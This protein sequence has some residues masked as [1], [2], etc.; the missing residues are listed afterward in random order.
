MACLGSFALSSWKVEGKVGAEEKDKCIH[1]PRKS[2]LVRLIGREGFSDAGLH[3]SPTAVRGIGR[4]YLAAYCVPLALLVLGLALSLLLGLQQWILPNYLQ[5]THTSP[6][7][8]GMI[9]LNDLTLGVITTMP[10]TFGEELGWRGYLLPR[11][12]PVGG[13]TAAMIVGV[14]WGL[15]HAPLIF[16]IGYE[17]GDPNALRAV[18]MF[19]LP[20]ITLSVFLA[21]LR[22]RS[23]SIWPGVLAHAV[24]NQAAGLALLAV[25]T[26]GNLY[27]GAPSGL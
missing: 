9:C 10:F 17:Y 6:A 14:I 8:F 5:T 15:W 24:G 23:G 1:P 27:M 3:P 21:W 19:V 26:A 7:V 4:L 2:L 25:V 22:F 13:V 12:S 16:L 18:F 11:L 20:S